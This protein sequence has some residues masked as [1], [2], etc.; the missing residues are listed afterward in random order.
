[1]FEFKDRRLKKLLPFALMS[2]LSFNVYSSE[3]GDTDPW[4]SFNRSIFAMNEWLDEYIARPVAVGYRAVTPSLV[5]AGITNFFKNLGEVENTANSLLQ[6]KFADAGVSVTRFALNST[7]GWF[8]LV[9]IAS[10]AGIHVRDEDFGQTL[11]YWGVPNGPYLM[12][13]FFGPSTVRDTTGRFADTYTDPLNYDP[14]NEEFHRDARWGMT[15]V[16]AID[17]RADLLA[18]ENVIFGDDKYVFIRDAYLQSREY[19]VK[20]GQVEDPFADSMDEFEDL[21]E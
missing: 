7:V 18:A 21:P 1:M 14:L 2:L 3:E 6:L 10:D 20:D 11:G 12:L 9:D 13:P 19:Q 4:E 5:D 8:G 15:G 16:K 17:K